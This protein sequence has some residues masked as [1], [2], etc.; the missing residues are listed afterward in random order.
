M[1][2]AAPF[3]RSA[4]DKQ[5]AGDTSQGAQ[6][7]I[8]GVVAGVTVVGETMVDYRDRRAIT[9]EADYLTI[10]ESAHHADHDGQQAAKQ[11]QKAG[12]QASSPAK[13]DKDVKQTAKAG[14]GS[15]SSA[16]KHAARVYLI[17]VTPR[18]Q[19]CECQGGDKKKCDLAQLEVGDRVEVE[20]TPAEASGSG[21]TA[22]AA[23]DTRHGRH[24]MMRGE[25]AS[26]AILHDDAD[27]HQDGDKAGR[28]DDGKGK[29]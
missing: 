6:K 19:V 24:R 26:I 29:Q 4:D 28:G 18:T 22:A 8:E 27:R 2:G 13:Q 1:A 7:K 16:S 5:K 12:D 11:G 3:A 23:Q 10:V 17:Q 15:E 9:A 20:F 14:D 25:A 21:T